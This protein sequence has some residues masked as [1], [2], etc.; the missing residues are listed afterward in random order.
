MAWTLKIDAED[1]ARKDKAIEIARGMKRKNIS[2]E[3]II[4]LTGLTEEEVDCN[5][6]SAPNRCSFTL[7]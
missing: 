3:T 4:E 5:P 2:I 7:L 1:R 6:N